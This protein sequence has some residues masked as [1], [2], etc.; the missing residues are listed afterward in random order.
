MTTPKQQPFFPVLL[1]AMLSLTS[2]E[3]RQHHPPSPGQPPTG[4]P[5]TF[6]PIVETALRHPEVLENIPFADVVRAS[7]GKE[8]IPVDPNLP[9]DA[10]LL[11]ALRLALN[12][13][14]ERF[15]RPDSPALKAKRVNEMSSHF[16]KA[17]QA[18]INS[19]DGFLCAPPL[20][21]AGK[22]QRSGYPDLRI[23]HQETGQVTYLDP[24]LVAPGALDSSLR[25][26]YFTPKD[27]TGKIQDDA[28]HLL[29]GIEHDGNTG[30]W[31]F[32]TWHLVDLAS[33][34]VRLKP[35]FQASNKDI[36]QRE[37]ILLEEDLEK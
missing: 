26:F 19:T 10:E 25:T 13:T 34:K 20:T 3:R 11:N 36:Y 2:C 12:R 29:V 30:Q 7:S 37:L 33:F 24:K 4:A 17:L 16:E 8:M 27:E 23:V 15:N 6:L 22:N 18:E 31:K 28:H 14:L 9:A 35:E 1:F 32:T 5:D 21:N